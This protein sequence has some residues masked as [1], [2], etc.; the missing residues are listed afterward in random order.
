MFKKLVS[1]SILALT[2]SITPSF[3]TLPVEAKS[4]TQKKDT[5]MTSKQVIDY[6]KRIEKAQAKADPANPTSFKKILAPYYTSEAIQDIL[7]MYEAGADFYYVAH[8][9]NDKKAKISYS[10]DKKK[11]YI[12]QH[13]PYYANESVMTTSYITLMKDKNTWKV[14][15]VRFDLN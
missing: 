14:S 15:D 7:D 10:K 13:F 6:L 8:W 2:I 1:V 11:I 3:N 4:T 9:T 5:T 12:T